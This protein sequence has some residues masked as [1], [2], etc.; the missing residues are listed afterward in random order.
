MSVTE[1]APRTSAPRMRFERPRCAVIPRSSRSPL[2]VV[3]GDDDPLYRAGIENVLRNAGVEVVA[4]ASTADDLSRKD[5]AHHPD[6][7]VVD[8][9]MPPGLSSES[10]VEAVRRLRSIDPEMAVVILSESA[11]ERY[12]P[13]VL[14]DRPQ[15]FGYLLK[16]RIWDVEDFTASVCR[17]ARGGTAIDPSLITRLAGRG[18][19]DDPF[20]ALTVRERE[21][22][23]LM[24]EGR[25]NRSIAAE[26]VVTVGAVDRHVSGIFAKLDLPPNSADHRRVLAVRRYIE[27]G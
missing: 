26:L 1:Q 6:V 21:V 3:V 12:V 19:A 13:E 8:L 4:S 20:D 9:H 7:A 23:A 25:S 22:Y 11:D 18:R 14:D 24:A 10:G 15:G 16:A 2:R 27:R 5:R 17:V